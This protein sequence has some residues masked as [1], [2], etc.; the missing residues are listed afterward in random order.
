MTVN[1]AIIVAMESE[2]RHLDTLMPAWEPVEHPVWPILRNGDIVCIT[3]GI[4]MVSAA[5]ATEHAINT[6]NP[7]VVLNFGCVGAHTTDLF[8][9]AVVIGDRLVHQGRMRF[10]P[11]GEIIPLEEGFYVPGESKQSTRLSTDSILRQAAEEVAGTLVFNPPSDEGDDLDYGLPSRPWPP[12]KGPVTVV[13]GTVSSGDIWLQ[14]EQTIN[15]AH[16][17]TESLC[18]DM[19]AASIAQI[20]ALYDLPFLTVKDVSNNE[21]HRTTI[22][23]GPT[24]ELHTEELGM[25]SAMVIVA[26]IEKLR[27]IGGLRRMRYS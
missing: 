18:E 14:S 15:A 19:E 6:Y 8:P 3:S 17:R 12:N 10:A 1:V 4:G 22:F 20:C 23:S 9:G 16:E 25:H 27:Q 24:S 13:T 7:T 5:A 2:R 11:D 21:L 26:V